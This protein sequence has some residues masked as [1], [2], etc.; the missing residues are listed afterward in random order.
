M[1][2]YTSQ[3]KAFIEEINRARE[4][5]RITFTEGKSEAR[6]YKEN[7]EMAEFSCPEEKDGFSDAI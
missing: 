7:H 3:H 2:R 5:E 6:D 4:T 1:K